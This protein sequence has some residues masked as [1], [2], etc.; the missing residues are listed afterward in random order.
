MGLF[1]DKQINGW[2]DVHKSGVT[3]T[4]IDNIIVIIL[5]LT[6]IVNMCSQQN[7]T[8]AILSAIFMLKK[9]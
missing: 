5:A 6:I 9:K 1:T 8:M 7:T 3:I 4:G 2:T